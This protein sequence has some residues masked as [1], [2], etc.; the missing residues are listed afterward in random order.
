MHIQW[1]IMSKSI[2][3]QAIDEVVKRAEPTPESRALYPA[4]Q[5]Q[6]E[7]EVVEQLQRLFVPRTYGPEQLKGDSIL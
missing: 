7:H 1:S 6:L 2:R 5:Q 3:E 4:T